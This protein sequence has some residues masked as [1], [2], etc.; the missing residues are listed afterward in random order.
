LVEQVRS[1]AGGFF[2][3][4]NAEIFQLY[5]GFASGSIR[6][7]NQKKDPILSLGPCACLHANIYA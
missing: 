7:K 4:E 2:V 3:L 6:G 5:S 1:S